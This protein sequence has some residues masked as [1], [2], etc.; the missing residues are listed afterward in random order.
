MK[1]P[2]PSDE[3]SSEP[4]YGAGEC[5]VLLGTSCAKQCSLDL[6]GKVSSTFN[7]HHPLIG[8]N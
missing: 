8:L 1:C 6:P 5:G 7:S 2:R 3:C 4:L